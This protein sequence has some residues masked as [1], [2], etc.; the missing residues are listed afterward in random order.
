MAQGRAMTR[1]AAAAA[2]CLAAGGC[3][4]GELAVT[5]VAPPSGAA[6]EVVALTVAGRGFTD[7]TTAALVDRDGTATPLAAVAVAPPDAL[8]G[9]A[10]ASLPRGVYDLR[11]TR[12]RDGATAT[13]AGAY[14]AQGPLQVVAV[15]VGEGDATLVVSPTGGALLVDAGP[16]EA[17]SAVPDALAAYGVRRLDWMIVTHYHADHIGGIR[18]VLAGPDGAVGTADDT[19]PPPGHL[20]DRGDNTDQ[21]T[22]EYGF[23]VSLAASLRAQAFPGQELDLG[24][25]A[26][27][28][29]LVVN[30]DVDGVPAAAD[31]VTRPDQEN[32]NCIAVRITYEDFSFLVAGDLTGNTAFGGDVDVESPLGPV[33]GDLDV[34][35]VN[36]HGSD[37]SSV[38]DF[39]RAVTPEAS[40]LSVGADN[41]YCHP[42]ESATNRLALDGGRLFLTEP[43]IVSAGIMTSAGTLCPVTSTYLPA[44]AV[45]ADGS[46]VVEVPLGGG[47]YTVAGIPFPGD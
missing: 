9:E 30:G 38:G 35:R 25:G 2:A 8:T 44:D 46:V 28:R 5:S 33:A 26:V 23:Y 13:A 1:A 7:D 29:I 12:A 37:T 20:L 43:G 11:V 17:G 42:N 18:G 27:A 3:G 4:A 15:D 16:L 32:E 41:T 40:I 45:V 22:I 14:R 36:H 34:L 31:P 47:A 21:G 10:P 39:L 19:A 24:G 6:G